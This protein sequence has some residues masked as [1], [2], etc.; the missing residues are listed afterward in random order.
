M[1]I[2]A[3]GRH[4]PVTFLSIKGIRL[5]FENLHLYP[6]AS[7]IPSVLTP[8]LIHLQN[9]GREALCL[10][11]GLSREFWQSL[12]VWKFFLL[13][14]FVQSQGANRRRSGQGK[15]GWRGLNCIRPSLGFAFWPSKPYHRVNPA[16]VCI[17][18]KK[19][20]SGFQFVAQFSFDKMIS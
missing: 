12:W 2:H 1:G 13:L 4:K 10:S 7:G 16:S 8:S 20:Q 19:T 18:P 11:F 5:T 6:Q 15:C 14:H 17:K 3:L 9:S